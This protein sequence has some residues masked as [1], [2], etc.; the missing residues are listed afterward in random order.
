MIGPAS[1]I[2]L[3]FGCT[4]V[5]APCKYNVNFKYFVAIL[6]KISSQGLLIV[7]TKSS[8]LGLNKQF[9]NG[10]I[11]PTNSCITFLA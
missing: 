4:T 3:T 11:D 2:I 5:L 9:I 7:V 8:F 1:A 6:W 10:V